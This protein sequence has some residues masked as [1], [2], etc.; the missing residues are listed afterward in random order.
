MQGKKAN[1][2]G[3]DKRAHGFIYFFLEHWLA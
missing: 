2:S 1:N 3:N